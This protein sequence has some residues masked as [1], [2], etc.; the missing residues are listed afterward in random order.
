MHIV[1]KMACKRLQVLCRLHEPLQHRI[2]INLEHPRRAPDAQAF[3]QARDDAH[4]ELD[5]GTLAVQERTKGLEKVATTDHTQQLLPGT[6]IGTAI[7]TAIGAE[8][9]PARPSPIRTG[10]VR[11]EMAGGIDLAAAPSRRH[12]AWWRS[13]GGMRVRGGGVLTGV[14]VRLGGEARK[15]CGLTLAL[16]P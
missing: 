3:G 7:G 5:G 13:C 12:D 11:A 8:I 10:R 15:G 9:A 14:A 6:T 2:G 16:G 4:D 1:E